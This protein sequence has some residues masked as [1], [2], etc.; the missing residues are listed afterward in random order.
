MRLFEAIAC[1]ASA[2]IVFERAFGKRESREFAKYV[3][4][5]TQAMK[6]ATSKRLCN[7]PLWNF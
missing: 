1:I 4:K 7:F 5:T 3:P 2:C 6:A